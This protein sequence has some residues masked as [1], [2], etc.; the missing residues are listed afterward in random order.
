[1]IVIGVD[2][3]KRTH[4]L[5]ALDAGTGVSRGESTIQ[6]TDDGALNAL[7]FAAG[8]DQDRVWAVE[9]CR[10]VT[11][12][13]ERA[14]L[15]AG[16][17]VIRVP[18]SLTG[19]SRKATRTAGKSDPIDARAVA[20]AAIRVG[21]DTLPVAFLD[22]RAME[23]RVLTDYRDQI[24]SE[25]TRMIN[26]LRWQRAR[27]HKDRG[28]FAAEWWSASGGLRPNFLVVSAVVPEQPADVLEIA[29]GGACWAALI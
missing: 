16:E 6:A 4:T 19:E 2:A 21:V 5:V 29:A 13:L 23:I 1:M 9:D 18:P 15:G 14:L 20:L 7:R 8:V 26:R 28:R 27:L 17:R 25:R 3:H 10:H 22:E 12:R 11:A 24:I